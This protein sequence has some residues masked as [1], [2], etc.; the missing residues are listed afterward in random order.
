MN[1]VIRWPGLIAFVV[2]IG[3]LA[4]I[5]RTFAGPIVK[6]GLE[7][8]LTRA[9]GAEVNIASVNI[10]WSPFSVSMEELQFTDPETPALNRVQAQRA[11]AELYFWDAVIGRI[12][13]RDLEVSGIAMGVERRSPGRVRADYQSDSEPFDWR[14]TLADLEIE[15]PT[16]E[17][18]LERSEIR[19]PGV[20]EQAQTNFEIQREKVDEARAN[21]PEKEKLEGYRERVEAI[22]EARPRTPE[23]LLQLREDLRTLQRDMRTDRD[24]VRAFVAVS[25]EAVTVLRSDLEA[26]R[27]APGQD[28]ERVRSLL[29]F[30]NDSLSE[31]SGVLFGPKVEQWS[32][33]LLMAFDFIGPMLQRSDDEEVKPSR[34]EGRFIDFDRAQ[35]PVFLIERAVTDIRLPDT[36]LSMDWANI[37]WQHDRIGGTPSTFALAASESSW[38]QELALNGEFSMSDLR[39]FAGQQAWRIR[40]VNLV[41][42]ELFAQNDVV[43]KLLGAMLNSEGQV[44]VSA[45]ELNGSGVISM[46]DVALDLDGDARWARILADV[47]G[48]INAFDMNLNVSGPMQAPGLSIRSDLDNQLQRLMTARLTAEAD[49]QIARLRSDLEQR[50]SSA[51]ENLDPR[52]NAI[53][54][55]LAEGQ[56]FEALLTDLLAVSPDDLRLGDQLR[57][58]L[59]GSLRDRIGG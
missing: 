30:D 23:E 19:T 48:Q 10:H 45:G 41:E 27:S 49:E 12:H 56:S 39:G 9:N 22:T 42:Q 32:Q 38:W 51:T 34:W 5:I 8:G 26:V 31:L 33:Y 58:R 28:I 35:R 24:A 55:G 18:V 47:V 54:A 6:S 59:R 4:I 1:K 13:I 29:R 40:G 46:R 53:V 15:I 44:G 50:V 7:Y 3:A 11:H 37:T 52:L 36:H 57:D 14:Q 17:G 16:V 43:A 21:L 20:I 2:I 25:E